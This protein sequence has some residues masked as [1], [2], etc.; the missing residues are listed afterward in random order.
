MRLQKEFPCGANLQA[1]TAVEHISREA[2]RIAYLQEAAEGLGL[3]LLRP[4]LDPLSYVPP[5]DNL[6]IKLC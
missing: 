1:D 5:S 6:S 4:I 3:G 2:A